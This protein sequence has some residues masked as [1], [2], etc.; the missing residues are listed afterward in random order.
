MA[1]ESKKPN[2]SLYQPI[3]RKEMDSEFTAWG[4]KWKISTKAKTQRESEP[5]RLVERIL[6]EA[7]LEWC[8][9][10]MHKDLK[11]KRALRLDF[12]IP[13]INLCIEADGDRHFIDGVQMDRDRS[14]NKFCFD[15]NVSMLRLAFYGESKKMM[16]C[17]EKHIKQIVFELQNQPMVGKSIMRAIGKEYRGIKWDYIVRDIDYDYNACCTI[18]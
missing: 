6:N 17:A 15:H 14:K 10:V 5:E 4:M 18:M 12:Y 16:V 1:S 9:E 13:K 2:V 11:H 7:K 3:P 8:R